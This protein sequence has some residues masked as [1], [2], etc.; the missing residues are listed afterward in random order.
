MPE[1]VLTGGDLAESSLA[2]CR[3]NPALT[4]IAFEQLDMLDLPYTE[5]FD[6]VVANAVAVYFHWDEYV[7][8]AKSVARALRAGGSY[9][10]FEWLH[11]FQFQDIVIHETTLG[12]PQGLRICFRPM[13]RVAQIFEQ[14]GM[15]QIEF[16]PFELPIE[17]PM[18]GY[19]QEVVSYT[20]RTA[21]GRNLCFRGALSQ[22]WCHLTAIKRG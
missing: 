3:A 4:G 16:L 15:D 9:L 14:A 1:L 2:E 7:R 22:P 5:Q 6:I 10:A 19:D 13:A 18:P 21:E 17:L 11:P 8:A 12:H 20:Q